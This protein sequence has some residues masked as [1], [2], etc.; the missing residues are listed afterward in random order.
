MR[1]QVE[2]LSASEDKAAEAADLKVALDDKEKALY[3]LAAELDDAVRFK[4]QPERE[5]REP[6]AAGPRKEGSEQAK[7]GGAAP[8]P[9]KARW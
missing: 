4:K 9:A 5:P 1:K 8:A 2:E 7:E 3:K 6:R